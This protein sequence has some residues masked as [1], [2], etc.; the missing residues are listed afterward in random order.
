MLQSIHNVSFWESYERNNKTDLIPICE[1]TAMEEEEK[2]TT[3]KKQSK[4]TYN[5]LKLK[6]KPKPEPRECRRLL[7]RGFSWYLKK[8]DETKYEHVMENL[9]SYAI[10]F[11]DKRR[12]KNC[13]PNQYTHHFERDKFD[14]VILNDNCYMADDRCIILLK[15]AAPSLKLCYMDLVTGKTHSMKLVM[16]YTNIKLRLRNGALWVVQMPPLIPQQT[17]EVLYILPNAS[18]ENCS[19]VKHSLSLKFNNMNVLMSE[20]K[21]SNRVMLFLRSQKYVLYDTQKHCLSEKKF[22]IPEIVEAQELHLVGKMFFVLPKKPDKVHPPIFYTGVFEPEM[23]LTGCIDLSCSLQQYKNYIT[24]D[25]IEIWTHHRGMKA[26]ILSSEAYVTVIDLLSC[27]ATQILSYVPC[28]W[29]HKLSMQMSTKGDVIKM[30]GTYERSYDTE[31]LCVDFRTWRGTTL[32][33]ICKNAI[34]SSFT[35]DV[36]LQQNLPKMLMRE[37]EAFYLLR[38]EILT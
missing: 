22:D 27:K 5:C 9:R 36:L 8:Y 34:T 26:L 6:P 38:D 10:V 15:F 1:A 2:V 16:F 30:V 12:I 3:G 18:C 33:D 13:D 24:D 19:V 7:K 17:P 14:D 29:T 4:R 11:H 37:L 23:K 20:V 32:K 31:Y 35:Y 25:Y 28:F 21:F